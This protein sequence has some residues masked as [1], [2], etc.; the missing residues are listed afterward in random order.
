M[1]RSPAR[2]G[3]SPCAVVVA[4]ALLALA[5]PTA[6]TRADIGH[7]SPTKIP[8]TRTPPPA[9][10]ATLR[11]GGDTIADAIVIT[12][13]FSGEGA[14]VGYVDDY[15]EV[16]P[17]TGSTAPDVVYTFT[18][19][20]TMVLDLDLC[21]S[22]YDTKLYVYD[23]DLVLVDCNDDFHFDDDCGQ[24]VSRIQWLSVAAGVRYYVVIDGYGA[25][26]G[27]YI[28]TIDEFMP[29]SLSCPA[30]A[31]LEGEP[32]LVDG[33]IDEFN[34]GCGSPTGDAFVTIANPVFCGVNGW[35]DIGGRDY[36]DTDWFELQIPRG[37]VVEVTGDAEYA[38]YL[39]ELAPTECGAVAIVQS[40]TLG[41]CEPG[42]LT[43]VGQPGGVIWLWVGPTVFDGPVNEYLY[44]LYLDIVIPVAE[45]SWTAVKA[46]F[47]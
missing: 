27:E 3:T 32:P 31:V 40:A 14:T 18:A 35:Y 11:Q 29:C 5:D 6:A 28:L 7:R 1:F 44:F 38:T 25:D 8:I 39:Y 23:E 19:P 42:G 45:R 43:L 26:A 13:P 34:G 46:L 33:Y 16:C 9:D 37:A 41:P 30:G 12:L 36:R 15:D 2:R 10:P 4:V 22:S 24:Y 21:G 47:D 17:Y 20:A